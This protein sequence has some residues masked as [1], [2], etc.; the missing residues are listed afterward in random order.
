MQPDKTQKISS[1][2]ETPIQFFTIP[3][4]RLQQP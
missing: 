2:N 3:P 1:S 4:P